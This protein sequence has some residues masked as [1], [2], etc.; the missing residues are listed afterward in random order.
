MKRYFYD[1][2]FYENGRIIEPISLGMVCD[3]GRELYIINKTY[4]DDYYYG[5]QEFIS[6]WLIENVLDKISNEDI[7][8]YGVERPQMPG[9]VLNFISNDGKV[10][11]RNSV[12]L[13]GYYGAYDH[14]C[15]A[16]L[17]GDMM[18]LPQPIP[19]FTK[20]IMNEQPK[21]F[22]AKPERTTPEHNALADA[23]Y[24]YEIWKAWNAK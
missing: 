1:W 8:V 5:L 23:K 22:S 24:Q 6:D 2:E 13:W 16:Q 15:L 10:G 18:S 3:D 4:M 20:E 21:R 12:E 19:M 9:K 14:V 17:W 7:E 11:S